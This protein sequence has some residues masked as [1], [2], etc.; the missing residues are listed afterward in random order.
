[1]WLHV[2]V[3]MSLGKYKFVSKK[4]CCFD[5]GLLALYFTVYVY[6]ILHSYPYS[7]ISMTE[8]E[9]YEY[10]VYTVFPVLFILLWDPEWSSIFKIDLCPRYL[11]T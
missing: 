2:V 5:S 10:M 1:M 6:I 7:Y 8:D 3:L 11:T 9:K 4:K